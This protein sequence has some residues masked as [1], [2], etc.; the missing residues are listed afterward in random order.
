MEKYAFIKIRSNHAII[1]QIIKILRHTF[2]D[3]Q[4]DIID[5]KRLL[6]KHFLILAINMLHVFKDYGFRTTFE[7]KSIFYNRF[8]GTPY[9]YHAIRRLLGKS[10]QADYLFTIQDCSLFNA[11]IHDAPN[12]VYTDHTVLANRNYP[13][14]DKERDMLADTWLRLE[15]NIY[16]DAHMVFTR[17]IA[18]KNSVI[19]DYGC[20]PAKVECIYYAPFIETRPAVSASE[21]YTSKRILFIGIEW[22][23]KGGPLLIEAFKRLQTII[24]DARLT[25]AGCSPSIDVPGVEVV[26]LLSQ[27][28]LSF[29][30]ENSA[31]FCLPTRR[32]PFGIVFIEAMSYALPVIGTNIGALPEFI[33]DGHNGYKIDIDDVDGLSAILVKLL[34]D[35]SMCERLGRQGYNIY[36]EKF[37][38]EKTSLLLKHYVNERISNAAQ[39]D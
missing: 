8:F 24:P 5:V 9:M 12:F 31:V 13:S 39:L 14:Y 22:E 36:L 6:K 15:H 38:L 4:L 11:K 19:N 29:F 35:P 25:I 10:L 18:I 20:N 1:E 28:Q 23:R 7:N 33:I 2:P 3:Y 37:T 26:G 21:K 27:D 16:N 34:T 17:S 32:E 30:Y